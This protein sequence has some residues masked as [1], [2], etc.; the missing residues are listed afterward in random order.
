MDFIKYIS[1]PKNTEQ[2]APQITNVQLTRGKITGG[3]IN[4]P[5]GPAGKLHFL[6][7][8]GSHQ[9]APFNT[10]ENYALDDAT[11]NFSIDVNILEPPYLVN[12]LTWNESTTYD[13]VLTVCF[14]VE[15]MARKKATVD[16]LQKIYEQTQ[17]Y[18]K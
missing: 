4:F 1:T 12:C 5:S 13:H 7:K 17:G 10:G 6:A 9:I 18:K 16:E 2:A 14:F 3:W 15:P 11:V 8:I